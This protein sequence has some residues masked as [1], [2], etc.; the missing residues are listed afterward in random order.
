MPPRVIVPA[1][2]LEIPSTS[3]TE[4]S[5]H[6]ARRASSVWDDAERSIT[7][8]SR[9]RSMS[10]VCDLSIWMPVGSCVT[11]DRWSKDTLPAF[12]KM[13]PRTGP[14]HTVPAL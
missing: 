11:I 5:C 9:S 10:V 14:G 6:G 1:E 13:R 4:V 8:L 2:S 7:C 12:T 3:S